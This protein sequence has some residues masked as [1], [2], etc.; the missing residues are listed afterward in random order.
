MGVNFAPFFTYRM[1]PSW[2]VCSPP[3]EK[4]NLWGSCRAILERQ[5]SC[6]FWHLFHFKVTRTK[7]FSRLNPFPRI[8][9]QKFFFYPVLTIFAIFYTKL[10]R[11]PLQSSQICPRTQWCSPRPPG[12]QRRY[13]R[14]L[15]TPPI[16]DLV[17]RGTGMIPTQRTS[18]K[19]SRGTGEPVK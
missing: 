6:R 16:V 5:L 7:A 9:N 11:W 19:N 12:V 10:I 13:P 4:K 14:R 3:W 8:F 18:P 15:K 2:S 1:A 17:L